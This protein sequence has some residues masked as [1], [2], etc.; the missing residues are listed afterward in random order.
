MARQRHSGVWCTS[1][2][3]RKS[4]PGCLF[5]QCLWM[6]RLSGGLQGIYSVSLD[7]GES[8]YF[9]G[10]ASGSGQYQTALYATTGLSDGEHTIKVV[11]ENSRNA[12][13]YPN[14]VYLDIDFFAL[15]GELYVAS[16]TT[17]SAEG[18]MDWQALID[19]Y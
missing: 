11:N 18:R 9:S 5:A 4:F 16:N 12:E 7:N 10:Y 1:R 3:P 8:Q 13:Q 15:T 14:Y 6:N 2:E 19:Q 17:G